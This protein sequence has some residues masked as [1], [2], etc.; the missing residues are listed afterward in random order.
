MP[1]E[2][3][4]EV[5]EETA[6]CDRCHD[7]V[8]IHDGLQDV[9]GQTWCENC[10]DF[11]AFR[12][13]DCATYFPSCNTGGNNSSGNS[14]C[15]SCAD[16]Y[17][18][19]DR[20][21]VTCPNEDYAEDGYCCDCRNCRNDDDCLRDDGATPSLKPCGR[22]KHFYG[23]EL[24]VELRDG[25][26][27]D[28]VQTVKNQ[29]G[30]HAICK[31][32]G[33]LNNGFEIVTSPASFAFHRDTLWEKF[34]AHRHPG[35]RIMSSCGL[36]VHCSREPLSELSIAKMVCFVNAARNARFMRVISGR[37]ASNYARYKKKD[38]RDAAKR[39]GDRYEAL[40]VQPPKT[41]EFR[42]FK[43]TLNRAK[44]FKALEFCDAMIHFCAPAGRSVRACLSRIKFCKFV[45]EHRKMYPH[46]NAFIAASWYGQDNKLAETCQFEKIAH[47]SSK[48]PIDE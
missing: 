36:H 48:K 1:T 43:A 12:C 37:E 5:E 18:Y 31:G 39:T 30:E 10:R 40:N 32:D 35:L 33:S 19:C 46:L 24:E 47:F 17:F 23:V 42:L 9:D 11:Y 15:E 29:L 20:C 41:I 13:D 2:P 8:S 7:A 44:F 27:C 6:H 25:D 22:G 16:N 21:H 4:I 34:F 26:L 45:V 38:I 28:E 14:V 3:A